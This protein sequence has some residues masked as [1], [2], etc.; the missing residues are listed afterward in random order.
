LSLAAAAIAAAIALAACGG[1]SHKQAAAT[2]VT[3]VDAGVPASSTTTS[4]TITSSHASASDKAAKPRQQ[5]STT[6]P[7]TA[8]Q[9]TAGPP[10]PPRASNNGTAVDPLNTHPTA[11]GPKPLACLS[12]DGLDRARV[13]KEPGVWEANYGTTSERNLNAVVFVDGPYKSKHAAD[14]SAATL[15]GVEIAMRGGLYDVTASLPSHL[16]SQVRAVADCLQGP[17]APKSKSNS[18]SF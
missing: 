11:A 4:A 13:G 9:T 6:F 15:N 7:T 3:V 18:Y 5:P 17:G 12:I 2:N 1:S 16:T 14:A 10:P 8:S